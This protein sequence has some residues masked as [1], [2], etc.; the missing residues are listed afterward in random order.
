MSAYTTEINKIRNLGYLRK[1]LINHSAQDVIVII[2]KKKIISFASNDYL[3]LANNIKIKKAF[4]KAVE[5]YGVGS[6]SSP[7]ISGYSLPHKQ[8]EED[9][10]QYLG[11]E[12]VLVTNSGYLS[13]VGLLNAVSKRNTVVF[14]DRQNHNSIIESSRLSS[15]KLIRYNHLSLTDLKKKLGQYSNERNKIIF[16]DS[17][18]SMTG[19]ISPLKGISKI[20]KTT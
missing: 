12:S 8:L 15:T 1:R 4:T 18:F 16:T 13:N 19:E 17:V 10:A 5:K 7:L 6:G 14:Q 9:I 3:G 20:S 11:F 2:D